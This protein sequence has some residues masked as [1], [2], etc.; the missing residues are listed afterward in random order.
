MAGLRRGAGGFRPWRQADGRV[1][2][3]QVADPEALLTLS[4]SPMARRGSTKPRG[5]EK[6]VA[7]AWGVPC[8]VFLNVAG[9]EPQWRHRAGR[10]RSVR[11]DLVRRLQAIVD[12]NGRA[13]ATRALS[14]RSCTTA[15]MWPT[16][17]RT[18]RVLRRSLLAADQDIEHGGCTRR[19][20]R[21]APMTVCTTTTG[22]TWCATRR[23]RRSQGRWPHCMDIAPTILQC[24]GERIP[25]KM[26]G[27][28]ITV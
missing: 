18:Y 24:L 2:L 15:R 13:M 26:E 16:R 21:S 20:P 5:R 28:A 9:R 25:P 17:A 22:C 4:P 11:D 1:V 23:A 8:R 6:T 10:V 3:D 7:W 19:R 12:D 27:N 14:P